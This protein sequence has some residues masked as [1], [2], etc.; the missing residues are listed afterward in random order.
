MSYVT[1]GFACFEVSEKH[2]RGVRVGRIYHSREAA[3]E[4]VKLY[5]KNA[6]QGVKYEFRSVEGEERPER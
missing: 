3:E 1:K 5:S 2:K 4:V 6:T